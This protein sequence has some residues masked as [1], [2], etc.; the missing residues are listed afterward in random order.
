MGFTNKVSFNENKKNKVIKNTTV[1]ASSSFLVGGIAAGVKAFDLYNP[2]NIK[3]DYKFFLD[4]INP[5]NGLPVAY[6]F[7][8]LLSCLKNL[9]GPSSGFPRDMI[10]DSI[11]E[12][13]GKLKQFKP[14]FLKEYADNAK[15]LIV[16]NGAIGAAVGAGVALFALGLNHLI[17]K[18]KK[19]A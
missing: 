1:V 16:K 8:D 12:V 2:K 17:N 7:K 14:T 19:Q 13:K 9:N 11:N 18:D 10:Q 5:N 6:G 3:K 15:K 4:K